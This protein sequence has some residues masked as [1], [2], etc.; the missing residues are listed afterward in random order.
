MPLSQCP[1]M[2]ARCAHYRTD[3]NDADSVHCHYVKN[4]TTTARTALRDLRARQTGRQIDPD[5]DHQIKDLQD[6]LSG[7][8]PGP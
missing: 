5:L 4:T 6:F 7:K 1:H 2:A 8:V 3:C